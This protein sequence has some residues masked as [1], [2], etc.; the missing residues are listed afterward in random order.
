MGK[1]YCTMIHP[2]S[3]ADGAADRD[4]LRPYG[5]IEKFDDYYYY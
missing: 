2:P 1:R 3:A 4:E 5:A